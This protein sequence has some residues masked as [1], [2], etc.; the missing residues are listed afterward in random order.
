MASFG[1]ARLTVRVPS[2]PG[3]V[4]S[5]RVA[6]IAPSLGAMLHRCD[7]VVFLEDAAGRLHKILSPV[8]GSVVDFDADI[9]SSVNPGDTLLTIDNLS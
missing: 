6:N 9:G 1:L 7:E 3:V 4:G 8:T 5:L 2:L